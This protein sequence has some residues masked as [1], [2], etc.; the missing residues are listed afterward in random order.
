[1][2][3]RLAFTPT[4]HAQPTP[5][6]D[7]STVQLPPNFTVCI[8]GAS[9][10][11]GA[12]IAHAY[13]LAGASTLILAARST[14]VLDAVSAQCTALRPA[15]TVH[16][17]PCDIASASSVQAL[18]ARIAKKSARLDVVVVNSGFAGPVTLRV[19]EG[20]PEDYRRCFDVNAVGTYLAAHH[21]LPLL[22]RTD[23]A[24]SFVVVSSA[25]AWLT[26]G[27][28]AN[29]GYCISKLAQLRLVE[30][31]SK[32]YRA[33]GLLTVGV[34]PGAVVTEMSQ[35]A[36]EEFKPCELRPRSFEKSDAT[37]MFTDASQI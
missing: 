1:M 7:P 14:D 6:T 5:L 3:D 34:H 20:D 35:D 33:E 27:I 30:M 9:R 16:R 10:G 31:M 12:S 11:I 22:L 2:S 18:A 29:T 8:L 32:Q 17:E 37:T 13:A 4:Q 26:E 36:P 28:I 15:L 25:A 24:R 23:G 21:L 19:T